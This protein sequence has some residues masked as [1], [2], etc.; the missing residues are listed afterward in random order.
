MHF[1]LHTKPPRTKIHLF[2]N[3]GMTIIKVFPTAFSHSEREEEN[4]EAIQRRVKEE[5]CKKK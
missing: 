3:G 1:G 5:M 4:L 2:N